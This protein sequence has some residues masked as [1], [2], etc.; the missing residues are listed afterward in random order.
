MTKDLHPADRTTSAEPPAETGCRTGERQ[1]VVTVD[2]ALNRESA[3]R[4]TP[5]E[6]Q[7]NSG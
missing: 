2:H 7:P 6:R 4:S 1:V 3:W 5:K